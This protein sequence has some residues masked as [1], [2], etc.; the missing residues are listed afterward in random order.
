ME[1]RKRR[2]RKKNRKNQ[3]KIERACLIGTKVYLQ[4]LIRLG[5]RD[6]SESQA[7]EC[8]TV[9]FVDEFLNPL[10]PG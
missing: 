5:I 2:I 8:D 4:F 3:K 1:E 10:L 6:F 9:N 7:C